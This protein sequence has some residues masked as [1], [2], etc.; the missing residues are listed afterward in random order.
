MD[1]SI[2]AIR[3]PD[4]SQSG[5]GAKVKRNTKDQNGP[6]IAHRAVLLCLSLIHDGTKGI[7]LCEYR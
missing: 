7:F 2:P 4:Q 1:G 5:G 6:V 3:N